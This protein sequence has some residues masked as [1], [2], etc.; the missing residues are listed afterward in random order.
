MLTAK[1]AAAHNKFIVVAVRIL[2]AII[3]KAT[4]MAV[5]KT[6]A[7]AFALFLALTVI[8]MPALA[9]NSA[10]Q[11]PYESEISAPFGL[12]WGMTSKALT[13]KGVKFF[14]CTKA[15]AFALCATESLPK[16]IPNVSSYLLDFDKND[17]LVGVN[18]SSEKMED[19]HAGTDKQ[20]S[21]Y[22]KE[23]IAEPYKR[24]KKK[25]TALYG[26]PF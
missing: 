20:N 13:A 25:I 12:E 4:A 11:N 26:A 2:L 15:G 6:A 5:N 14:T 3:P 8:A 18:Y 7:V 10:A 1:T 17:R 24:L 23:K 21:E 9:E 19:V 16:N 22:Y